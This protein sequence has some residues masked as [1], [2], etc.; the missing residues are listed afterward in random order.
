ME[1][2]YGKIRKG[3]ESRHEEGLRAIET[4]LL[5]VHRLNRA[6][7]SRRVLEAVPLALYA[8]ESR[9]TGQEHDLSAFE[10]PENL[11]LKHA[12]LMAFDPFTNAELRKEAEEEYGWNLDDGAELEAY[13]QKPVQCVLRIL[14]SVKQ[15]TKER[16]L[17]P[18]PPPP[19]GAGGRSSGILEMP[20]VIS[21]EERAMM[22]PKTW[23]YLRPLRMAP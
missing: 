5:T 20:S 14:D 21:A 9:L 3:E 6:C 18:M 11:K 17:M 13:Y 7:D 16:G 12:I 10:N 8:V 22:L 1:K 4:N 23:L 19:A 2:R 15:W